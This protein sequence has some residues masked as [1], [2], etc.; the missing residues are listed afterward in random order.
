MKTLKKAKKN[1]GQITVELL[2]LSVVL[3]I[4]AQVVFNKIKSERYLAPLTTFARDA[5]GN[6]IENGSWIRNK[7]EARAQHPNN[8][9]R[10]YSWKRDPT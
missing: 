3:I 8:L 5:V 2:L 10:H 6:M 1:K 9:E 7:E 4:I